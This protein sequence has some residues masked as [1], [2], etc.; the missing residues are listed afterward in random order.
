MRYEYKYIV[1]LKKLEQLREMVLPFVKMD[2]F[3]EAGGRNHY[4]VRSIY[5]DTPR[6]DFYYEK[7]EG[8]KNRKKV[9]LRGYDK[10]DEDSIVFLE[11]K[12]KYDVPIIK[13][14]APVTFEDAQNML[15]EKN[16][17]GQI[18]LGDKFPKGIENSKRFFYQ[19]FSKNLRPVVLVVYEREAYLSKFDS[20][21]RVTLDKNLRSKGYPSI[22]EL[23]NE[24]KIKATLAGNF[25]LEVKFNH[26]FPA[27]LNPII[28]RLQLR[29][30]SAS[31]YVFS[32]D[33]NNVV[34][35]LTKSKVYTRSQWFNQS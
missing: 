20:S 1:P 12:R 25:I 6:Y 24:E 18:L 15:R 22:N 5:F 33:A 7:I 21:V 3:V 31:K 32:M 17:N 35:G 29:K 10:G 14:R 27:W 19:V 28:S 13:Y 2:Q 8:I 4:T 23:Y 11:I 16:I 30:Q 26:S 9:R 34:K